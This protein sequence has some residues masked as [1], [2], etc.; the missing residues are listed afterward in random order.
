MRHNLQGAL[1]VY[2]IT[3]PESFTKMNQWVV[4]LKKMIAQDIPIVIAGNKADI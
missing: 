2:D 4:E 1:V 3:D